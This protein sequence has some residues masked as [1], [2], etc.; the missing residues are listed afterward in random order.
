MGTL[1]QAAKV[2][3]VFEDTPT[4]QVQA[5]LE[6]GFLADLRDAN[7]AEIKRDDFR[8]FVGL[9][10]PLLEEIGT[11]TI[12]AMTERFVAR[13]KFVLN[14]G[15]RAKPGARI[16]YLGENFRDWFLGKTE[17]PT[18][19]TSLRYAHLTRPE[20]DGLILAELGDQKETTLAEIYALMECQPNGELGV[21]LNNG[22]ANVFYVLDVNGALR[23][24]DVHWGGD[25]WYVHARSVEHPAGWYD[26]RQV[27][28]RN[29]SVAVTA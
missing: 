25:G 15:E 20:F 10:P 5:I 12:P 2:L 19:D 13:D 29:S 8:R 16:S 11:I 7:I 26:G 23:A 27:F 9:N 28:S 22:W 17:E 3:S 18:A 21:L 4:E 24:V 6:S 1:K 14:C